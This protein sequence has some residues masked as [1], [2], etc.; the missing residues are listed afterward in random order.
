M[1]PHKQV[2]D[3]QPRKLASTTKCSVHG[4]NEVIINNGL[5]TP[6]PTLEGS[7]AKESVE[8]TRKVDDQVSNEKKTL[9]NFSRVSQVAVGRRNII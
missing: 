5:T 1:D 8:C 6:K 3:Q 4:I 2:S 9:N 7:A